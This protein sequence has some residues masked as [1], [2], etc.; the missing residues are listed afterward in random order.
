MDELQDREIIPDPAFV[1]T[2][3]AERASAEFAIC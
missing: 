2:G 3:E 1:A